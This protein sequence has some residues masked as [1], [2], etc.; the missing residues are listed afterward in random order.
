[1]VP[2]TM[3]FRWKEEREE[4]GASPP[5]RPRKWDILLLCLFLRSHL[6]ARGTFPFPFPFRTLTFWLINR[7]TKTE[8]QTFLLFSNRNH[9]LH[10]HCTVTSYKKDTNRNLGY[11][12]LLC[13]GCDRCNFWLKTRGSFGRSFFC[14]SVY[15]LNV[16]LT[17]AIKIEGNL[18]RQLL[19]VDN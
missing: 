15:K 1:M 14:L 4:E 9:A 18:P 5:T 10:F 17:E 12:L 8:R 13:N 11:K 16:T 3:C 6:R 7:N 2:R 19:D